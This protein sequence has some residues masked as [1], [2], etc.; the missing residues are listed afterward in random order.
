[1]CGKGKDSPY[2][3]FARVDRWR[4]EM[5]EVICLAYRPRGQT[6]ELGDAPHGCHGFLIDTLG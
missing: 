4:E 3:R 2:A 6:G 1:M 5:L